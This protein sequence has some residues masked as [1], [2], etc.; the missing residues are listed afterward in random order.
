MRRNLIYLVK[1]YFWVE[2][3]LFAFT[4]IFYKGYDL[5]CVA[6]KRKALLS[7]SF[8]LQSALFYLNETYYL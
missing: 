2:E 3:Y 8:A 4:K 7:V 5:N 1:V 6:A